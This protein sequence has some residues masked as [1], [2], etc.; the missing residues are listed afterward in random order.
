MKILKKLKIKTKDN[1]K[2]RQ[3]Y[4]F[5]IPILQYE[6]DENKKYSFKLLFNQKPKSTENVFYLKINNENDYA[7]ICFQNWLDIVH[8]MKADFYI[9]CDK[10]FVLNKIL[11]NCVFYDNNIKIIKSNRSLKYKNI[12]KKMKFPKKWYNAGF[13]HITT[14]T[15]SVS[16]NIKSCWNI[17]ADDTLLMISPQKTVDVLRKAEQN[18]KTKDY[19]LYSL[20]MHDSRSNGKQWTF[21]I[22]YQ[23]NNDNLLNLFENNKIIKQFKDYTPNLLAKNLDLFFSFCRQQDIITKEKYVSIGDFFVENA[24][25]IHWGLF[26]SDFPKSCIFWKDNYTSNPFLSEDGL[27]KFKTPG[28][29]DKIDINIEEKDYHGILQDKILHIDKAKDYMNRYE[30]FIKN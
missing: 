8:L 10:D 28:D 4:F 7:P 13:S 6:R 26:F 1:K 12:F 27:Y 9:I 15:H 2:V 21:G 29:I 17:D 3:I 25:F 18:V 11:K 5:D 20:D 24:Y 16:N 19:D 30:E 14:F 23:R 22:V